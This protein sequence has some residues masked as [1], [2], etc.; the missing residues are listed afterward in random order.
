[1]DSIL[2]T[3]KT[4]SDSETYNQLDL[5]KTFTQFLWQAIFISDEVLISAN[6]ADVESYDDNAEYHCLTELAVSIK[7]STPVHDSLFNLFLKRWAEAVPDGFRTMAN[8]D[9]G[10]GLSEVINKSN[11]HSFLSQYFNVT[12]DIFYAAIAIMES[13][14]LKKTHNHPSSSPAPTCL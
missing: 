1:M 10:D 12:A 9:G 5:L 2:R 4:P 11:L 6:L 8:T 7:S 3:L 13:E 14:E